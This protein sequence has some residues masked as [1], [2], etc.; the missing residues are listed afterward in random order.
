MVNLPSKSNIDKTGTIKEIVLLI[1]PSV[2]LL[3][4][5]KEVEDGGILKQTLQIN[6]PFNLLQN[7]KILIAVFGKIK[8]ALS[9]KRT[10]VSKKIEVTGVIIANTSLLPLKRRKI[11]GVFVKNGLDLEGGEFTSFFRKLAGLLREDGFLI[12][13]LESWKG[14]LNRTKNSLTA[15]LNPGKKI[16]D[17]I[18]LTSILLRSGFNR[19]LKIPSGKGKKVVEIIARKNTL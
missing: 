18:S 1:K 17:E 6:P 7:E 11:A 19:I 16:P 3:T 14:V 12:F 5:H 15:I 2:K 4:H 13:Y 9:F 10:C 8:D